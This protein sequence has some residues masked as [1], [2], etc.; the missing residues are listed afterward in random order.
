M[1]NALYYSATEIEIGGT[2]PAPTGC[3]QLANLLNSA[4]TRTFP[5]DLAAI[6][7]QT[8][9]KWAICILDAVAQNRSIRCRS[10][11]ADNGQFPELEQ[12]LRYEGMSFH[13]SDE[14][15]SGNPGRHLIFDGI[16]TWE[17]PGPTDKPA[18]PVT[19]ILEMWTKNRAMIFNIAEACTKPV[20]PLS[21][22]PG[23]ELNAADLRTLFKENE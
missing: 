10:D 19:Q 22:E 2:L 16:N 5:T 11:A 13:R 20:K 3:I 8:P 18:L 9:L 12:F 21:F 17:C 6:Y 15:N 1:K 23:L 4:A 7:P 14:G